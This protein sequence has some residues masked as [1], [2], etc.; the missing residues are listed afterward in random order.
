M[1]INV[2]SKL[3]FTHPWIAIGRLDDP[4]LEAACFHCAKTD[5][6]AWKVSIADTRL[7]FQMKLF[8]PNQHDIALS[9]N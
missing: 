4:E 3:H 1:K 8:R 6:A 5:P 2:A 7:R 9:Y